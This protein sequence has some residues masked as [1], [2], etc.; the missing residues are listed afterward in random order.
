MNRDF[1]NNR[2]SEDKWAYGVEPNVFIR[3]QI[4]LLAPGVALFPADGEGRNSIYA[5]QKGWQVY[6]YD[7]SEIGK[8]KAMKV[9]KKLGVNIHYTVSDALSYNFDCRVKFDLIG[10]CFFHLPEEDRRRFHHSLYNLLNDG[11]VIVME[12]YDKAQLSKGTG[13]P[14]S[15]DMLYSIEELE[16]DF[17][18]FS[19]CQLYNKERYLEEGKYHRGNSSLIEGV[20]YK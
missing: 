2:Y 20:I 11:G 5:A 18:D 6:A 16:K 9:A 13:G 10:L 8:S 3:E 15:K 12:A 14:K 4:D 17:A 19:K 1:W 7:Q